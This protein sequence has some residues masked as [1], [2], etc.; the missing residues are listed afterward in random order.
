MGFENKGWEVNKRK[1]GEMRVEYIENF[2]SIG[3]R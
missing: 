3:K 2:L 1:G